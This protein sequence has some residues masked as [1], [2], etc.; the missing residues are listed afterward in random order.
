MYY[1]TDLGHSYWE[2]LANKESRSEEE[3]QR[4]NVMYV[5]ENEDEPGSSYE[6]I[7]E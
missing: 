4:W 6:N 2:R 1:V 7:P 5:V 3:T